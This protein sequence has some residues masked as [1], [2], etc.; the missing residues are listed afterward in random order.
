VI[1]LAT[2]IKELR[3]EL[4]TAVDAA[5]DERIQLELG[6]IELEVSVAVTQEGSG[7]VKVRFWVLDLGADIGDTHVSTQRIKLT[8]QPRVRGSSAAPWV[9]GPAG[10]RER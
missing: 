6:P 8:L 1:E 3:R 2:V 9:A 5:A 10:D 4:E 7:A